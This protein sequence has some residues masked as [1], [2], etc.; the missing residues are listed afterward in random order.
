MILNSLLLNLTCVLFLNLKDIGLIYME[1]R[2]LNSDHAYFLTC[3]AI[4]FCVRPF[5]YQMR[6]THFHKRIIE[7]SYWIIDIEQLLMIWWISLTCPLYKRFNLKKLYLITK[8]QC[9][10]IRR[11]SIFPLKYQRFMQVLTISF[12]KCTEC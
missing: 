12:S 1:S 3:R 10:T 9:I 5:Q 4:D 6:N 7:F 8:M 11:T 2:I